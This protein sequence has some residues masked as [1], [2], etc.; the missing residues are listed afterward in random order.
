MA[1][2]KLTLQQRRRIQEK[3]GRA[4][5][6]QEV[7]EA[8]N[9]TLTDEQLGPE[10]HGIIVTRY[11]NQADVLPLA[12]DDRLLK[13]CHFRAH[14]ESPVTGDRVLW[15]DAEPYGVISAVLPR[16]SLLERP[17]KRGV[18]RPVAANIDRVLIVIAPK[19][20]PHRQLIDRYLVACEHHRVLPMI[21]ANKADM[22]AS[23][24]RQ[25]S[26]ILAPYSEL[27]YAVLHVSAKTGSG[28]AELAG[29]L[30]DGASV[31]VGQSGVGKSSLINALCPDAAAKVGQL[32]GGKPK[33]RHT[34]T[35]ANLFDLPSGGCIIDSPGIREFGLSH[36]DQHAIASG[37]IEFRPW[38][39]RC[40]FRDCQHCEEP[41]C[42]LLEAC[43]SGHISRQRL[44][45]YRQI[46]QSPDHD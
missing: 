31:L 45:S 21:I 23:Q 29:A 12:G 44:D 20:E 36:L 5:V 17:D 4:A 9:T 35:T 43:A 6:M 2:S 33:G 11:S 7:E 26:E 32:S 42:A 37:F 18:K 15:H 46:S 16:T 19:P 14:L 22:E 38:L 28:L 41:G 8:L 1:K 34:T 27:G 10:Q 39:G 30:T 3:R 40:R 13:R 24:T 25:L